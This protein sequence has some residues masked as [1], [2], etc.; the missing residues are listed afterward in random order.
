M[1]NGFF[2]ACRCVTN[3]PIRYL[4]YSHDHGDHTLGVS[5]F[6][7]AV[8]IAHVSSK[9]FFAEQVAK[10]Y[11][12]WE[13]KLFPWVD[14]EGSKFCYPDVFIDSDTVID[15]G[16]REVQIFV[17]KRTHTVSA[18][19]YAVVPDVNVVCCGDLLFYRVCPNG[20][21]Q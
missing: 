12:R 5:G 21:M 11:D 19:M 7:E 14:F 8:Q 1:G 6:Q 15:L 13:P 3:K 17:T 16:D 2:E 9:K 20:F 18:S 4:V 10:G